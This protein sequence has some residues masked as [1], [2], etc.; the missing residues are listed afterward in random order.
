M[1][2]TEGDAVNPVTGTKYTEF[3]PLKIGCPVQ[4]APAAAASAAPAAAPAPA[5]AATDAGP[6]LP[7]GAGA[8]AAAPTAP[9]AAPPALPAAAAAAQ[10]INEMTTAAVGDLAPLI[11]GLQ[12]LV[13]KRGW[14]SVSLSVN[15]NDPASG[16]NTPF[17]VTLKPPTKRKLTRGL[18]VEAT[19][20]PRAGTFHSSASAG[21]EVKTLRAGAAPGL[22]LSISPSG[23]PR[24]GAFHA[25]SE[26]KTLRPGGAVGIGLSISP[27]GAARA[28]TF[29]KAEEVKAGITHVDEL[30]TDEAAAA[31][32]E[33]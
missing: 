31:P 6:P 20:P 2:P 9:P 28:G 11:A 27:H 5:A 1:V 29:H 21:L 8:A 33:T 12:Q 3:S 18:S 17:Q 4:G 16:D 23:P 24:A 10:P 13:E 26:V 25:A 30:H 15:V 32:T 7:P 14:H 22:G 19:G